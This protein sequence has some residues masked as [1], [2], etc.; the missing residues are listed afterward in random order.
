MNLLESGLLAEMKNPADEPWSEA[1]NLLDSSLPARVAVWAY[2]LQLMVLAWDMVLP[3]SLVGDDR[4]PAAVVM[5]DW[6]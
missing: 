4:A 1:L 5:R 2:L 6:P 3:L